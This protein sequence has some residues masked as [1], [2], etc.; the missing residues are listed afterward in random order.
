MIRPCLLL[1]LHNQRTFFKCQLQAQAT[2]VA[3]AL[4]LA[5]TATAPP[6]ELDNP[7]ALL[8]ASAAAWPVSPVA[9]VCAAVQALMASAAALHGLP[10]LWQIKPAMTP[11]FSAEPWLKFTGSAAMNASAL[12]RSDWGPK[13]MAGLLQEPKSRDAARAR[14]LVEEEEMAA[15]QAVCCVSHCA[16]PPDRVP[17]LAALAHWLCWTEQER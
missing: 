14:T 15:L 12:P 16:S 6:P 8:N 9:A 17:E 4:A 11:M 1:L 13:S 5:L 10:S 2:T 3:A 7:N